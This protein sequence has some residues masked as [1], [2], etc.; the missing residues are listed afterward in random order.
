MSG[1]RIYCLRF[2]GLRFRG[3]RAYLRSP[4]DPSDGGLEPCSAH[5]IKVWVPPLANYIGPYRDYGK[6]N[7]NYYIIGYTH[8]I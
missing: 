5:N 4:P 6:E 3:F 1:L 8:I 7:V 2:W